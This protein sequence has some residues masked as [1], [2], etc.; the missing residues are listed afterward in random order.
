M[1]QKILLP[2]RAE[3]SEVRRKAAQALCASSLLRQSISGACIHPHRIF[4]R[5]QIILRKALRRAFQYTQRVNARRCQHQ[6][7][8]RIQRA[9]A[10]CK[11][12]RHRQICKALFLRHHRKRAFRQRADIHAL[13]CAL[14]IPSLHQP[15]QRA[16]RR[17][18]FQLRALPAQKQQTKLAPLQQPAKRN[19]VRACQRVSGKYNPHPAVEQI[20]VSAAE[21]FHARLCRQIP[22]SASS[23]HQRITLPRN[24]LARLPDG[25][26]R[27]CR[28]RIRLPEPAQKL[29]RTRLVAAQ[30]QV[31]VKQILFTCQQLRQRHTAPDTR[32]FYIDHRSLSFPVCVDF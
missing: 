32:Q 13:L 15:P 12:L 11:T 26:N 27:L 22:L 1:P 5:P 30:M 6:K 2:P 16:R 17:T 28:N 23:H 20:P 8:P 18:H 14:S 29:R 7:R 9:Y 24:R 31:R 21:H 10:S 4:K 19:P 3:G 25:V